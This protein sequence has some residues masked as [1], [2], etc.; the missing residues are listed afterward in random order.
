[1]LKDETRWPMTRVSPGL[2]YIRLVC[3]TILDRT[4]LEE[5][6]V[7][8]ASG[9]GLDEMDRKLLISKEWKRGLGVS[10]LCVLNAVPL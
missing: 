3:N 10:A 8:S 1:V 9:T 7:L 6:R 4:E 5:G 2:S